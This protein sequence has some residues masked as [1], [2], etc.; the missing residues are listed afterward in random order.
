M[1]TQHTPGPWNQGSSIVG[2]KCVWQSGNKEP[3]S[4]MGEDNLWIDCNT[5][6]DARLVSAAPDML[7]A[8][9]TFAEYQ[10]AMDG[11]DDVSGTLIY[12]EFSR[13]ARAAIA[14]AT[15]KQ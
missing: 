14:K 6:E 2:K 13:M 5:E 1:D 15:G 9:E 7:D 11:G 12:A 3:F 8:L 10:N 4:G